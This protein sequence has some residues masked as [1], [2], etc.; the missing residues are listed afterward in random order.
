MDGARLLHR[1]DP[2]PRAGRLRLRP[3]RGLLLHR[4]ILRRLAGDLPAPRP[5]GAAA[6]SFHRRRPAGARD[7][8]H[9]HR[10]HP[11]HLR[12]SAVPA[13]PPDREPRPGLLGPHRMECGHGLLGLRG[14]QL[15]HGRHAAARHALR[16]RRRVHGGGAQALGIMGARRHRR[17]SRERHPGGPHQGPRDRACR[18]LLQGPR[19]AQFRTLRA[20]P[21]GHRPGRGLPA[22]AR[23]RLPPRRHHRR[24]GQGHGGG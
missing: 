24:H 12:L 5:V 3:A 8:A 18:H 19:A 22:R 2:E 6:G 13:G 10:H 20:G 9:R 16:H 23:I 15:R 1:D 4:R 17:G 11:R 7:E 14:A 21:A